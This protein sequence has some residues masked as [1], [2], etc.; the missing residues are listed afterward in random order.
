MRSTGYVAPFIPRWSAV[1]GAFR[2]SLFRQEVQ[3]Q[4]QDHG[5]LRCRADVQQAHEGKNS[6][7]ERAR[8]RLNK[9]AW[10]TGFPVNAAKSTLGKQGDLCMTES[11][12]T[13]GTYASPDPRPPPFLSTPTRPA[14]IRFKTMQSL[15]IF[16]S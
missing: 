11:K 9:M 15:L 13:T 1:I 7:Q 14:I 2:F 4:V 8:I 10:F 5:V 6:P 3:V 12:N 16:I